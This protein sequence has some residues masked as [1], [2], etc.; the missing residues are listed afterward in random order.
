M[1]VADGGLLTTVQDGGRPG[2]AHLGVPLAGFLDPVSAGRANRLVGNPDDT[3]C[4][5]VTAG[6]FEM[7]LGVAMSVAVTGARCSVRVDGR[8]VPWGQALSLPAGSVV[9]L[10]PPEDGVRRYVAVAGGIAVAP[11]L[12]SRS[13]DTLAW[14]GPPPIRTG[15]EIPVGPACGDPRDAQLV[16]R[17]SRDVVLRYTPGPRDDWFERG[18]LG[19]YLVGPASNRIG[20]RLAG[21]PLRRTRG[22]QGRELPSEGIVLGAIQVPAD[23]QPL[24]FLNDHPT[25]GGYPV[26][27]VVV[28]EDLHLCAQLAPGAAVVFRR[29]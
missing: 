10:G 25:T 1:R 7:E 4:F 29:V 5:E 12:G 6:G 16:D 13:T 28:P 27:G 19:T 9:R 11:V 21:E 17:T 2:L 20:M 23:G 3:A 8:L 26:A 22:R 18:P 24:V 15:D 14:V